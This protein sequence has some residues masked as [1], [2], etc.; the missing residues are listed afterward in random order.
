MQGGGLPLEKGE[1]CRVQLGVLVGGAP[2][3]HHELWLWVSG[4]DP[5]AAGLVGEVRWVTCV[6]TCVLILAG[7]VSVAARLAWVPISGTRSAVNGNAPS[8]SLMG[9]RGEG[10][11]PQREGLRK[12]AACTYGPMQALRGL[13][14]GEFLEGLPAFPPH[15]FPCPWMALAFGL[16]VTH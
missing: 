7:S 3:T 15:T 8:L 12:E 6:L 10:A 13:A 11:G 14:G 1:T 4:P 5:R 16:R 9:V 2:L